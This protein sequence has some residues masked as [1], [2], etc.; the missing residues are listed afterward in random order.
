MSRS[1]GEI[2]VL[3]PAAGR[4]L[5]RN[6]VRGNATCLGTAVPFHRISQIDTAGTVPLLTGSGGFLKAFAFE[7]RLKAL[8]IRGSLAVRMFHIGLPLRESLYAR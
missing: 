4:C 5:K 2:S 3:A 7:F 8:H 6:E 1:C